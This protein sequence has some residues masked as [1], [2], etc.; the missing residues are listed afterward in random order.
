MSRQHE[1]Y[2]IYRALLRLYPKSHREIYGEQIVQTLDD[3]LSDQGRARGRL[4]V[5]LRVACELPVNIIEEN[6]NNKGDIGMR[7]TKINNRQLVYGALIILV[8]GS[9]VAT[10]TIWRH[11]R[12]QV[13]SLNKQLQTVSQNQF[14]MSGG[15]YNAA[16]IIPSENAVYLPLAKLKL[17]ASTLNE[18]LVYVYQVAH[19]I[20]GDNKTFPAQLDISTHDLAVNDFSTTKQF[21]CSEAVY[22]DF[23]S[24]SYPLNPMWKSDGSAKLTD[25]RTMN[26]YYAPSIS[27]CQRSWESSNINSKDIA[28]SLMRAASY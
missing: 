10:G 15:N 17:T 16:T 23:I 5:W 27:G 19:K 18:G 8:A 12:D 25:G 3:I 7:I 24:P 21:D 11:Q 26:V 14:A 20:P 6:L 9:Y 4:A 2:R 28:D 1:K 22:A 13:D